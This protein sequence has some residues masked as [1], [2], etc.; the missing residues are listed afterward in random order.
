MGAKEQS[1]GR[2]PKCF[3]HGGPHYVREC[4]QK[5]QLNALIAAAKAKPTEE[6]HM[7]ALRLS[8]IQTNGQASNNVKP[9]IM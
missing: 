8:A 1:K 2:T 9:R 4:P 7:G 6:V 5:K 3:L